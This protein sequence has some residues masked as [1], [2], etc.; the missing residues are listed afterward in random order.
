MRPI[1]KLIRPDSS[2]LKNLL[3][4][5]LIFT[6]FIFLFVEND[7]QQSHRLIRDIWNAGHLVLF[8]LLSFGYLHQSRG[9]SLSLKHQII[10]IT[11]FCLLIG[12]A[13]EFIQLLFKREFSYNDIVN[14]VIGGYLGLS[15]FIIAEKTKKIQLRYFATLLFIALTL[16]GLRNFEK[17]LLDEYRMRNS[18]PVIADFEN[19]L[20]LTRWKFKKVNVSYS[21]HHVVSGKHSLEA[22]LLPS[23]YPTASLE[24]LINDW[25]SFQFLSLSVYNPQSSTFDFTISIYDDEH[26]KSGRRYNDRFNKVI[27]LQTGWNNIRLSINDIRQAPKHRAMKLNQ[28]SGIYMFA[29]RLKQPRTIY[30]DAIQLVK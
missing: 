17:H 26:N 14:D 27:K 4:F 18:F 29:H 19:E 7:V 5:S 16:L 3:F 23:R 15:F 22:R 9:A 28:I 21:T 30:I 25:R 24:H 20:E 10:I 6:L 11:I 13:I 1:K 8:G 12:A 2:S